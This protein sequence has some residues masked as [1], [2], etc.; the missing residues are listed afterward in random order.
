MGTFDFTHYEDA[1]RHQE[2]H[3]GV[4]H[5]NRHTAH[6][7]ND[8]QFTVSTNERKT[9]DEYFDEVV[10]MTRSEHENWMEDN[11]WSEEIRKMHREAFT[12]ELS[13]DDEGY[14]EYI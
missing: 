11:G 5:D 8:N 10:P 4:I 7:W 14:F 12:G 6:E 3:G 9:K 2:K 1:K 13:F